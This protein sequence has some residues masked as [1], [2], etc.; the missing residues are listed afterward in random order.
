MPIFTVSLSEGGF[1]KVYQGTTFLNVFELTLGSEP[2]E[3]T[4]RLHAG[5]P[6][7]LSGD[8]LGREPSKKTESRSRVN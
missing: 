2:I 7:I 5:R 6:G 4:F 1:E 3:I 8:L